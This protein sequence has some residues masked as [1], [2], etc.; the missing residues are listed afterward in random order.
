[1]ET[2]DAFVNKENYAAFA[3]PHCQRTHRVPVA[4]QKG[5]NHKLVAN[6]KCQNRFQVNLNYRQFYRKEVNLDG[7]VQ[8]ATIGSGDWHQMVVADLSLSGLRFKTVGPTDIKI[9]HRLQVRFTLDDQQENKIEKE[10]RVVHIRGDYFGC[11]F[12]NLAYQEKELGFY[13]LSS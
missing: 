6:C 1:M 8:N 7:E 13:I 9:G 11:E 3:C 5:V 12:L 2:V 4:A 10:A